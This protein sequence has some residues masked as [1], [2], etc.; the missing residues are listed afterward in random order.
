MLIKAW[1]TIFCLR[2]LRQESSKFLCTRGM[3]KSYYVYFQSQRDMS[4]NMTVAIGPV[5][6]RGSQ[7]YRSGSHVSNIN[8]YKGKVGFHSVSRYSGSSVVR[9]AY[10]DTAGP[11]SNPYT[12]FFLF[13]YFKW[14]F[15]L[16]FSI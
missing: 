5:T 16:S 10:R 6:G 8:R 9:V 11:G 3:S 13:Y 4:K 7:S 12:V 1:F 14:R 2:S 15:F